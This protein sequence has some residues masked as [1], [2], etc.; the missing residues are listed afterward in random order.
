MAEDS[1]GLSMVLKERAVELFN[2]CDRNGKGF[3]TEPDLMGVI[4]QLELPLDSKQVNEAFL[5]LDEDQNGRLT[6]EEF[7]AGFGLF[8]GIHSDSESSDLE[9]IVTDPGREL[10]YL[11]DPDKKGYITKSDLERVATDLNLNFNQLDVIFDKLDQDANGQLTID[12]FAEGFGKFLN[13]EAV[14]PEGSGSETETKEVMSESDVI[15]ESIHGT[16]E[17]RGHG[18]DEALFRDVVES[19]G[20]D[21]FSG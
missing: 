16:D 5:K 19:V 21:I 15:F 4:S 1:E 13:G 18:T 6:L 17:T 9:E 11:C 3:I 12:E 7:A 10:F 14:T 2:L 8:L 20:E